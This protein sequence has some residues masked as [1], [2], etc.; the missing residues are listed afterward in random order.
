VSA[1]ESLFYIGQPA[2]QVIEGHYNYALVILSFVIASL[3]SYVALDMSAQLRTTTTRLFRIC[4]I[5]GGAFV[6]GAGIWSMHFI[7]M[8]AYS[9]E[10]P[11]TYDFYLTV[12]SMLVAMVTAGIAFLFFTIKNPKAIHYVMSGVI[13]GIAIPTMHYTGMTGMNNVKINYHIGYFCL[14]IVIAVVAATVALWLSVKSDQGSFSRRAQLKFVSAIIMGFAIAG[15][16]YTGMYAAVFTRESMQMDMD[17]LDPTL[18]SIIIST[19]VISMLSIALIVSTAKYFLTR[20]ENERNF[21]KAVLNNMSDGLI[22]CDSEGK[23]T[24]LNDTAKKMYGNFE[25]LMPSEWVKKCPFYHPETET[26]L[27]LEKHPLYHALSGGFVRNMEVEA[28]NNMGEKYTLLIDGQSICGKAG[29][30][31]GAVIVYHDITSKKEDERLLKYQTMHDVLTGLPNRIFLIEKLRQA[32]REAERYSKKVITIFIDID[33]F[34][35]INDVLGHSV[36]DSLLKAFGKRCQSFL[37]KS[38]IL[39]RV[40]GDEFVIVLPAQDSISSI[41]I[42]LNKALDK[43]S[44]PY[45]INEYEL[46]IT[47]SFG[48]SIFPD[49]GEDPETLLRNSDTAMYRAKEK[50]KNLFQ[51]YTKEMQDYARKRL[52][53]ERGLRK[54]LSNN[55]FILYYQ[56][57]MD[58]KTNQLIGFEALIRWQHPTL[59]IV[60]PI[61]FI[62]IAEDTGLIVPIGKWVIKTACEQNVIWQRYATMPHFCISVNISSRQYR[63]KNLILLIKEILEETKMPSEYLEVELTESL[64][65]NNPAEFIEILK[66][67]KA[68]GIKTSIDDFGTGYS[69]LNYLRQFA[70]NRLKIDQSFVK[71]L[72]EKK[73]NLSIIKAIISLGH[74]L[75]LKVIAEG[76]ETKE[77]L[78]ILKDNGCDEIQGYYLSRPIPASDI[79]DFIRSFYNSQR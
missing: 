64:A 20:I 18:L 69:S 67:F 77:Q 2:G 40:G 14:S 43:L 79:P 21:L 6:M 3:A 50:G 62:S 66:Q 63:D 76:V 13:L 61:E 28:R 19:I 38:D 27:K 29:E 11:M 16:H 58:I 15:M 12:L 42:F 45:V 4:W 1:I 34:K 74:S 23:I 70:V 51:I 56:A 5:V 32:S 26:M 71:E 47:C 65:M 55:E 48:V 22:S 49:D 41:H 8:L 7:G 25:S 10:M 30:R 36:G 59:G 54:A 73:E 57:K 39:A 35:Y 52:E 46:M 44:E 37:R 72:K 31:A 75:D 53:T 24:L 9:M 68:L 17:S 33:D 78:E 60:S